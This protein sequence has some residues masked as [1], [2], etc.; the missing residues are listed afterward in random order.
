MHCIS[1]FVRCL[2]ESVIAAFLVTDISVVEPTSLPNRMHTP[3]GLNGIV[4]D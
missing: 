2:E 4:L 3:G 1:G